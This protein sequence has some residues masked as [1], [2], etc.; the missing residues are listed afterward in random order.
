VV[1][2]APRLGGR[3]AAA[4]DHSVQGDVG[5]GGH[6]QQ[7]V[8]VRNQEAAGVAAAAATGDGE[9]APPGVSARNDTRKESNSS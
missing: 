9:T 7:G 4:V 5:Q 2:G 3:G 6:G 1:E 8:L